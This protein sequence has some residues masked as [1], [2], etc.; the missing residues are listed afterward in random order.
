MVRVIVRRDYPCM[1]R[2]VSL[3]VGGGRRT[4]GAGINYRDG[5]A[6]QKVVSFM[7]SGRG[8]NFTV[9]AERIKSG[10]IEARLGILVSDRKDAKALEIARGFGM[11]S[12]FVDPKSY[13]TK[14]DHERAVIALMKNAGTDLIVAAGY[15]RILTPL[16]VAEFRNRIINIHPALLPSFPGMDGQKQA[17]DYGVKITGCTTHFIDEGTDSGPIIMQAPV[18]VMQEDTLETLA[19]RILREEHRILPESVKLFCQGRL[20][21][22]GRKVI[23]S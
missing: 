20:K 11:D 12:R 15:M 21:V 9:V 8:S 6:M 4:T 19:Q 22:A 16:F 13:T 23:L 3:S 17:F 14:A 7:A 1:R 10:D 2:E 5:K 18:M